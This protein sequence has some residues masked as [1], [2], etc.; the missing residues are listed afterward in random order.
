MKNVE[1]I[2]P[3]SPMQQG[4]LFHTLQ[5]PESGMYFE[6]VSGVLGG[7]EAA[8]FAWAWQQVLERHPVLRT[9]FL[10]EGL[11]EPLQVVR[12][13]ADL[14]WTEEDWR[15]V[16]P[17]EQPA[18]LEAF[19]EAD[20]ARGFELSQAPLMRCAL[21]RVA[22]ERYYFVWSHHHLL[23][24]GWSLPLVLKEVLTCYEAYKRGGAPRLDPARPYR[25]YIAW[26]QHQDLAQAEGYWREALR[27]FTAPTPLAIGRSVGEQQAP[28]YAEQES[29]VS[30][31]VTGQLQALARAH[32]LTL[33]TLVQG[34]WAVLLARYSGE[35]EVLFGATVS[36]RPAELVGVEG[37]VGLFINTLP[38]RVTLPP[39]ARLLPWLEQL[40][41]QQVEREQYAYTPLVEIQGWSEVPRGVPLFD[42]LV[43]FENYPVSDVLAE[44]SNGV[45][46]Q[47]VK[48]VEWT[49]YPLTIVA[50]LLGSELSLKVVYDSHPFEP[51]SIAR[52]LEHLQ[53]VLGGIAAVPEQPLAELPLLPEAERRQV[54]V[55]WNKT[56]AD[57]PKERCI[58]QLFEAQAEQTP[59]AVAVV[60]EGHELTYRVLNARAN[61]LAHYLQGLGV[62]PE[63]LVG[64]C[65]E[66]SL[67][68]V[69]GL[70]GVLKAGG[71]YVPLDPSYPPERLAFMLEDAHAQVLLTQAHLAPTLPPIPAPVLCLDSAW[72]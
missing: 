48:T 15:G 20:R 34:A 55:E 41:A 64:I 71:A 29:R 10:W 2:Y 24:D 56:A 26:L 19:L 52:L 4:M 47:E 18:R 62:G 6:Q 59:E 38:V 12:K 46:T 35:E 7:V 57:Y 11:E 66:R 49:N 5:A 45:Q 25:D 63:R 50:A 30:A 23:L 44:Q 32:R 9:A 60:Y 1:D 16:P 68:L 67:E 13:R 8:G 36:G 28:A 72:E 42:S 31:A 51:T 17:H 61:Q 40:Q 27:G 14:S 3:L 58:H 54:V 37:M 70:L 69:V 33:N 43:V 21:L 53:I 39:E 65:L 22:E